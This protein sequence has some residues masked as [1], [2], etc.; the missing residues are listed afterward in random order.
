MIF[1]Q[2]ERIQRVRG[3]DADNQTSDDE[4]RDGDEHT[5]VALGEG[6]HDPCSVVRKGAGVAHGDHAGD[7]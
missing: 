3:D 1:A 2:C 6:P 5:V 4:R 7:R